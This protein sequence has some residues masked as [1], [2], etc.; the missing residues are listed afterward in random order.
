MEESSK[1][2]ITVTTANSWIYPNSKNWPMN[3]NELVKE[4]VDC[5]KEGASIAHVHLPRGREE[6][7]VERIREKCDIIIQ[8]GMS[9]D[10]IPERKGDFQ[11]KPD[12]I[13]IILNH[14]DEH[15]TNLSVNK[16]H[17]LE[18]LEEY[19]KLC[20]KYSIKP[21][22]EVWN[23]GSYWNL[24]YLIDKGLTNKP[25]YQTL[26]FN[27]PGGTWSPP[28]LDEYFH[29]IKY[30]PDNSIYSV[31]VMG[32]EQIKLLSTVITHGG[33]IRVG[34]EDFPFIKKGIPAK[35]NTE[36]VKFFIELTHKLGRDIANPSEVRKMI[37]LK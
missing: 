28:T 32:E 11:A 33:N 29:R 1:L 31:S 20:N 6:E 17:T 27:W 25:H 7:I 18:E 3:D 19:C 4:V 14:H 24:Q 35:N 12:M 23:T 30:L 22:W 15:F 36:I 2:I 21:E 37:D 10:S 34:T 26:F 9:S 5:C 8:A 16:L 13:S